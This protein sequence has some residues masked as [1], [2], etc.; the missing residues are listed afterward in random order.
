VNQRRGLSIGLAKLLRD[1]GVTTG[2]IEMSTIRLAPNVEAYEPEANPA[3]VD[4]RAMRKSK[5]PSALVEIVQRQV[6][7]SDILHNFEM[8][9]AAQSDSTPRASPSALRHNQP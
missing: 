4:L 3:N 1:P 7:G 5:W 6:S 8:R 2:G 9:R